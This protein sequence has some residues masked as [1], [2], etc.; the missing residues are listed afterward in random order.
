V[1]DEPD[2]DELDWQYGPGRVALRDQDVAKALD[3]IRAHKGPYVLGPYV[4][5]LLAEGGGQILAGG[6][7][8]PPTDLEPDPAGIAARSRATLFEHVGKLLL[9]EAWR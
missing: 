8:P 6:W 9:R 4:L 5:V 1:N 2:R 3:A 7:M